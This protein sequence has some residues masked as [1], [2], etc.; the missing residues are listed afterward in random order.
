MFEDQVSAG[1][2][3]Q[4]LHLTTGAIT[5]L[6]DRLVRKQLVQR[7]HGTQDRRKVMLQLNPVGLASL[8]QRYASMGRAAAALYKSYDADALAIIADFLERSLEITRQEIAA[9]R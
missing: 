6:V 7:V 1:R 8:M 5:G 9:L 2:L 3:A 4:E